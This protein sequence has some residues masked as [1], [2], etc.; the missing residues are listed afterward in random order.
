[1]SKGNHSDLVQRSLDS[2]PLCP[3]ETFHITLWQIKKTNSS[4]FLERFRY[5][6]KSN[7]LK[8][9]SVTLNFTIFPNPFWFRIS[10]RIV[11]QPHIVNSRSLRHPVTNSSIGN[12][13]FVGKRYIFWWFPVLPENGSVY[14]LPKLLGFYWRRKLLN[15]S[16]S[17]REPS[18]MDPAYLL[19]MVH[20]VPIKSI[21]YP[22]IGLTEVRTDGSAIPSHPT[23]SP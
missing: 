21:Q 17:V 16:G 3:T 19:G 1:M 18:D 9:T 8:S 5:E 22:D 11:S 4:K 23:C 12:G 15:A 14:R 7:P 20:K 13:M 10:D 6:W 2:F